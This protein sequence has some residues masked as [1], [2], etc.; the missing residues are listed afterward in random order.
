[1]SSEIFQRFLLHK[2]C[3]WFAATLTKTKHVENAFTLKFHRHVWTNNQW[4][5]DFSKCCTSHLLLLISFISINFAVLWNVWF[6]KIF[7]K[8]EQC[9]FFLSYVF[10]KNQNITFFASF[11]WPT[12]I[13]LSKIRIAVIFAV[14]ITG[15][16]L[17]RMI[18]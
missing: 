7:C 14:S 6:S 15:A 1:M 9:L 11:E 5:A 16:P 10:F 12:Y 18:G 2:T 17:N 4:L 3:L 13:L 8:M